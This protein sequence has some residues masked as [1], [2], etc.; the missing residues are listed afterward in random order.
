MTTI[1]QLEERYG[2]TCLPGIALEELVC[3]L[4]QFGATDEEIEAAL[5]EYLK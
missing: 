5:E 1:K 3:L 2:V 4:R